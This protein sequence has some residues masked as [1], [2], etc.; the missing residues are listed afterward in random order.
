MRRHFCLPRFTNQVGL[1]RL[2]R[3][4]QMDRLSPER[5]SWN[6]S[7]IRGRDTTPERQVRSLL[8]RLGFRFRVHVARLPGKPDI[9]LAK[10][11]TV[12]VVHGCFWH[13]HATCKFAYVPK[14]NTDFWSKKFSEN[15]ARDR[16]T[17]TS[18]KRLGWRVI[19][20]WECEVQAPARL[21]TRLRR[22]LGMSG[23][24]GRR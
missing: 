14:S 9:V 12:I 8:H 17:S 20:V 13:R 15:V 21:R 22:L 18:L 6:M 11:R 3:E 16:R 7:R 10:H 24:L 23:S 5:R 1:R 19:T 4:Q 2:Y